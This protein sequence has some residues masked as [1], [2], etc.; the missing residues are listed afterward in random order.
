MSSNLRLIGA[1]V[2]ALTGLGACASPE[3]NLAVVAN[4][5][6]TFAVNEEQRLL[7]G[8]VDPE[9]ADFLASPDVS[10]RAVLTAPD[11]T[12]TQVEAEF[13]WTVPDVVGIYLVRHTFEQEGTWWV[14]LRPSGHGPTPKAAFMVTPTD[15]VPGVGDLAPVVQTRTLTDHSIE[16]ISTDDDPDPAFYQLSVD[17][18]LASGRPLVVVFA[19]PAFCVSQTCGPMLDQVKGAAADHPGANYVHVEI[20]QNIDATSA[21][22]LVIDPAVT[23]WGL[24][25]EPWVFVIDRTGRVAAR[26]EGAMRPEEL[27]QALDSVGA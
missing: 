4:A 21:E 19:T 11:S 12:E 18:A 26:F 24:P 23:A 20:Y 16:E 14:S 13:V 7:V 17:Q 1:C 3:E 5:P 25:S 27:E 9:T 10:A 15:P 8:L 22:D 2:L 6:G